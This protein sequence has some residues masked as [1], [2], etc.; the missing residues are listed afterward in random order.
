MPAFDELRVDAL[1]F[2]WVRDPLSPVDA[3][4]TW[5]VYGADGRWV[6]IVTTPTE[7]GVREIG[8]DYVLA[9]WQDELDVEHVRL[10]ALNR[11]SS[12]ERD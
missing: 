6:G 12:G 5:H 10:Y 4:G 11:S 1:G 3:E 9:T 2:L 8:E 7:I